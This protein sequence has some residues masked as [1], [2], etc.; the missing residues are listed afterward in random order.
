MIMEYEMVEKEK[1]PESH[2]ELFDTND[3]DTY[4]ENEPELNKLIKERKSSKA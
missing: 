3:N 4:I 2:P 1:H